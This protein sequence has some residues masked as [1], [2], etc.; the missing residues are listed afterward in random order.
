MS[1]C[2]LFVNKIKK[3]VREEVDFSQLRS[4][5]G[6]RSTSLA[7]ALAAVRVDAGSSRV[8]DICASA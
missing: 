3:K 1:F 4:V 7:A 5:M 6:G 2:T 8:R